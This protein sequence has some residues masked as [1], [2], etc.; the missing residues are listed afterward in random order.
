MEGAAL[1]PAL[2]PQGTAETESRY[3]FVNLWKQIGAILVDVII[4]L[5]WGRPIPQHA[6]RQRNLKHGCEGIATVQAHL[7]TLNMQRQIL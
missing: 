1:S 7:H 6:R 5:C 3:F 2:S 4:F